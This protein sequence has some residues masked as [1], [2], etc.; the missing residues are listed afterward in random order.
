M[1][2]VLTILAFIGIIYGVVAKV[3]SKLNEKAQ[4]TPDRYGEYDEVFVLPVGNMVL[5]ISAIAFV[6][7]FSVNLTLYRIGAQEVGVVVTPFTV[8]V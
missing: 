2:T 6:L 8:Y 4:Q 7:F 3:Q 1:L 5:T